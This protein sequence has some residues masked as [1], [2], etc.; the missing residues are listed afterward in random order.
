MA[1]D[2]Q[3]LPQGIQSLVDGNYEPRCLKRYYFTDEMVDQ[4]HISD[5][6]FQHILLRILKP[7]FK[8]VMN[9]NCYH[10]DGPTGVKN[11]TQ[12]IREVIQD[13]NP[14][15]FIRTD[16][17]SFYKSIP[18][19]KLIQDI[20]K[21]YDDPKLID[22]L[23]NIINNPIDTPY[24]YKN[25]DYGIALRGPLSQFFSGIYLKPLDD[26]ISKMDVTYLRYQDDIL[27]L[28]NT[29]RQLNR[30]KRRMMD[31]L[32]E[33]YLSLSRR[34]TRIGTIDAGFHFLGIA[35]LP[36]QR[37][38]K[39]NVTPVNDNVISHS[40]PDCFNQVG[41]V[42]FFIKHRGLHALF[43]MREHCVKHAS[44]LNRWSKMASLADRSENIL[45]D[46]CVGG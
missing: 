6:I 9:P 42:V 28:C 12:K 14:K 27:I 15:Y 3:W 35:Y 26:V 43:R 36:T 40:N 32:H 44:K 13:T 37:E 38:D 39:I 34:K 41:G 16:I 1:R 24:G 20:K 4:L 10:L 33:R 18:H 5:R 8:F 7:T 30:C 2:K 19:Y 45:F 25:P 22:M 23:K 31:V 46:G 29:K 11:A 17:K 21:Y